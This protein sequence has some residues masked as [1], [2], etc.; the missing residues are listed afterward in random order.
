MKAVPKPETAATPHASTCRAALRGFK[1][2][3]LKRATVRTVHAGR[4]FGSSV[5]E[6]EWNGCRAAVK[7]F[8]GAPRAF[9]SSSRRF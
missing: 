2:R 8:S 7:D 9:V 1:R 6:V 3:D 4:G 5:F